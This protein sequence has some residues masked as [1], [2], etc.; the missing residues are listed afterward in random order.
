[1]IH[2]VRHDRPSH[3]DQ[4][5]RYTC[6]SPECRGDTLVRQPWMGQPH[7]DAALQA[8]LESHPT[9]GSRPA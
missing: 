8:F 1:M 7:W 5:G 2:D 6:F 9:P 4:H 3:G